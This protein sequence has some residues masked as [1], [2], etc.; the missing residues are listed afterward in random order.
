MSL[1]PRQ[2][3]RNPESR[4]SLFSQLIGRSR[5]V[6]LLAVGAV[7]LVAFSL[8]LQGTVQAVH[9]V[10]SSWHDLIVNRDLGGQQV[11][12]AFLEIVSVMLK[13]VVFYLIGVGL[14]SL[15]IAP[16]NLASSLGVESLADLEH[17]V[18]S[19]IVVILAITF[20]EHFV[21]WD[22][23]TEMLYYGGALAL[24]VT[25]LVF[26]QRVSS[27][28]QGEDLLQPEAKLKAKQQLFEGG[29]EERTILDD[30][31][32]RAEVVSEKRAD[33]AGSE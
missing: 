10:Y 33:A 32:A 8:F 14:Y 4:V 11:S 7:M 13:A 1:S 24:V 18:I 26:F 16:L 27:E 6:V 17:K 28:H 23:P 25:A 15:F 2:A 9:A 29:N 22:K 20:L 19:V 30:E 12:I 21:R 5:F 31:V 3:A